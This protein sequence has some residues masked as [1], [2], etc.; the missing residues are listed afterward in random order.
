MPRK[1]IYIY[2]I[3]VLLFSTF[4]YFFVLYRKKTLF[5]SQSLD[6]IIST[7][8]SQWRIK[9]PS[10]CDAIISGDPSIGDNWV[11]INFHCPQGIKNSTLATTVFQEK[12]WKNIITEYARIIGFSPSEV[13][14]E[15]KWTCYLDRKVIISNKTEVN[16]SNL[17][18]KKGSI[19]CINSSYDLNHINQDYEK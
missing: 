7:T 9:Y 14:D 12:S 11:K 10:P 2:I 5:T 3:F 8:S 15:K 18:R 1:T 13:F 16:W 17:A 6:H 4:I 19:D